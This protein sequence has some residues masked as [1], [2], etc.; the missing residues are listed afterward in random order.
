M[1]TPGPASGY[2]P[3]PR[4]TRCL[5]RRT[6]SLWPGCSLWWRIVRAVLPPLRP[7]SREPPS[8]GLS[9]RA[10]RRTS[11]RASRREPS[12]Q[13]RR[14]RSTRRRTALR[15]RE[16]GGEQRPGWQRRQREH[17]PGDPTPAAPRVPTARASAHRTPTTPHTGT[18]YPRRATAC[19]AEAPRSPRPQGVPPPP[20]RSSRVVPVP[21]ER[22]AGSGDVRV[23]QEP[24]CGSSAS[25]GD[26][27]RSRAEG[28]RTVS[29]SAYPWDRWV[30]Q[31]RRRLP[32]PWRPR[33]AARPAVGPRRPRR[34]SPRRLPGLRR[35]R[36]WDLR[37]HSREAPRRP[38][39]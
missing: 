28:T 20:D 21:L 39:S 36:R 19:A 4:R 3:G 5:P 15:N 27:L 22:R 33:R 17:G 13:R 32:S 14:A 10:P 30:K 18:L 12:S 31:R 8:P 26:R 1:S 9:R 7:G 34:R 37:L 6:A 24:L 35:G 38:G 11:R 2:R 23:G 25:R 29:G 16:G